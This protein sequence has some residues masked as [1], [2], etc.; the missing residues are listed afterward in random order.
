MRA[1]PPRFLLVVAEGLYGCLCLL[2][3]RAFRE[4]FG[5]E[6]RQTFRKGTRAA[7]GRGRHRGLGA[8][9]ARAVWDV[10]LEAPA[11]RFAASRLFG[12]LQG[13]GMH[14]SHRTPESHADQGWRSARRREWSGVSGILQD[15]RFAARSYLRSPGFT[16]V[17]L[18]TLGLGIGAATSI[19]SVVNG[20]LLKPFPF[21]E[22]EDLVVL[23]N[24]NPE[25]E[26]EEYRIAGVDFFPI[27]EETDAFQGAAL[28]AGAV[29]SLTG[30][31]LPPQR[32]AGA[33][34]SADLFGVL[35]IR[36]ALGRTFKPEEN[37]DHHQVVILSHALWQGRFG[38]RADIVGSLITMD[39]EQVQ[40]V[41]VMPRISLPI[42]GGG[43]SLPGPDQPL[44]WIPLD[45][46]QGWV[47]EFEAHV[48]AVLARLRPGVTLA[49]A[50]ER[51]TALARS[52]EEARGR[53][54]Q[55]II[56]R[57]LREEVVGDIHD[58]LL[59]LMGA[60]GLL[61]LMACANLA[62]LFLARATDREGE[63]A[64]RTALGAGKSRLTRQILT[65]ILLLG[66]V[67]GALGLL[68]SGASSRW[69]L[70]LVP[71]NLPRQGEITT[72]LRVLLFSLGTVLL[73]TLT[74]G[75]VPSAR[76][77]GGDPGE[78]LKAKGRIRGRSR[79]GARMNRGVV[80]LQFALA[81]ILLVGA[82]LLAKT[83][84]GLG[85]VDPG[86]RTRG[87]LTAELIL[88]PTQYPEAAQIL[89][90]YDELR[91]RLRAFPAV[92]D[93]VLGMNHPLEN[94]WWNGVTLLDQPPLPS[95]ENP[96][97]IF[98]PVSEGY[99]E[100]FEIPILEGRAFHPADRWGEPGVMVVNQAFVRKYLTDG[101]ALGQRVRLPVGQAVW[102]EEAPEVFEIVG[103][104]GDV[105]FNGLR[106]PSEPAFYIPLAQFPYMAF[107]VDVMT[108]AEPE[109][110]IGQLRTAVW[111][112]DPELPITEIRSM[113]GLLA[114]AKAQDRFNALLLGAFSVAALMLAAAGIYGVLSY[115]VARRT[116][117]L[118]VRL[119]LG[120][121]PGSVLRL[122]VGDGLAMAGVGLT[123]GIMASLLVSPLLSSL[124]FGVPPRDA[125]VLGSVALTLGIVACASALFPALRAARTSPSKAIQE[126]G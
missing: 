17:A 36:P 62:N 122:V 81:T 93:V 89:V 56:V 54:G 41:G 102:G 126:G 97:G 40:V 90:F 76:A 1:P 30:D 99:F 61:L 111:D 63:L 60:V 14:G 38:G 5:L 100:A 39:G 23:W 110:F 27:E 108:R 29:A 84:H 43:I 98:R 77:G 75:L 94:T 65:E 3:P 45:Y 82:G 6:L 31:D 113:E 114:D 10:L 109:A 55:E 22:A 68:L 52:L 72:D 25:R 104:S 107:K 70:S 32:V 115:V 112:L 15:L 105:R 124:L 88:P 4:R 2:F 101:R 18:L 74:A 37:R 86:F 69:L 16:L 11:E 9:M 95:G 73:A 50:Q 33:A 35:G 106:E 71:E 116:T 44:F 118:G 12:T 79:R 59:V 119:A 92:T 49:Q 34:V 123:A 67:G 96:T 28:L 48:M 53:S 58:N 46:S 42:G 121:E 117:E 83:L 78:G 66:V 103:V 19:F 80:V 7:W 85:R 125:S 51:M 21:P 120:A 87:V 24:S 47:S 20:V 26:M 57:S 8:F 13:S 91:N 64:L